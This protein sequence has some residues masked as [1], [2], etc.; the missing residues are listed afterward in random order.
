MPQLRRER[1]DGASRA[2]EGLPYFGGAGP[3]KPMP[4]GCCLPHKRL[5]PVEVFLCVRM[6]VCVCVEVC[7]KSTVSRERDRLGDPWGRSEG[8][9]LSVPFM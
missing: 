5:T 9:D 8:E 3:L 7:Q 6:Y 2:E 1:G 4:G